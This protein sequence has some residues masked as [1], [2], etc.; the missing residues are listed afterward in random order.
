MNRPELSEPDEVLAKELMGKTRTEIVIWLHEYRSY[1][2]SLFPTVNREEFAIGFADW[3]SKL[4]PSQKVSVWSKNGEY[5]GLFT[6][7]NEQLL[8]EYKKLITQSDQPAKEQ[9]EIDEIWKDFDPRKLGEPTN[10]MESKVYLQSDP[11]QPARPIRSDSG[12]TNPLKVVII[13]KSWT[14]PMSWYN[15]CIGQSFDVDGGPEMINGYRYMWDYRVLDANGKFNGKLIYP[16][17]TDNPHGVTAEQ[18]EAKLQQPE[19]PD[20]NKWFAEELERRMPK[21]EDMNKYLDGV[22]AVHGIEWFIGFPC[23]INWLK[24]ELLTN[25]EDGK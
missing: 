15:D 14:H 5:S 2:A 19:Q 18:P 9:K 11:V 22:D 25:Q 17:D 23:G 3:L 6:M 10:F 8:E 16:G 4:T 21:Q 13:K 24:H 12:N 1:L 20:L 7:D